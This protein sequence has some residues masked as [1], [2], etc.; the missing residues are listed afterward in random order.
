MVVHDPKFSPLAKKDPLGITASGSSGHITPVDK[1]IALQSLQSTQKHMCAASLFWLSPFYCS[2]EKF[3]LNWTTVDTLSKTFFGVNG[4]G[5]SEV[6]LE[7]PV[8]TAQVEAADFG[9]KGTWRH[10]CPTEMIMAF[11][12]AT[13]EAISTGAD[14]YIVQDLGLDSHVQVHRS[15]DRA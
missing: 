3:P 14:L 4:D 6:P 2:I 13:A 7:V 8:L 11:Y 9:A 1:G 15:G 10:S 12:A 5:F